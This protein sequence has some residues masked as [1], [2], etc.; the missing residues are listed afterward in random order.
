M[1]FWFTSVTV[2]KIVDF[3]WSSIPQKIKKMMKH[4]NKLWSLFEAD[5]NENIKNS[6]NS[7][8]LKF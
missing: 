8:V 2:K 6:H 3:N 1:E 4:K 5:F 7:K